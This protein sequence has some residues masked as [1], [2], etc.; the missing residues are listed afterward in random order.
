MP[1]CKFFA[2]GSCLY[3]ASCR[4]SHD[5]PESS[6]PPNPVVLPPSQMQDSNVPE[7]LPPAKASCWFFSQGK[8]KYGAA[9]KNIHD[10]SP[11]G[12][13]HHSFAEHLTPGSLKSTWTSH[14]PFTPAGG[15]SSVI[16]QK[17]DEKLRAEAPS[18]SPGLA[19]AVEAGPRPF[20][21]PVP[22][23]FFTRGVCR[24]GQACKF[25]HEASDSVGP[26]QV[27]KNEEADQALL[28]RWPLRDSN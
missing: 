27:P 19:V 14:P 6:T 2:R 3:G 16:R 15:V 4:N 26:I 23:I 1:P 8:C 5:V 22:C 12:R 11:A 21:Q 18:F 17:E 28:V 7:C 9:C 24:R 10:V 20:Q 25:L 13:E